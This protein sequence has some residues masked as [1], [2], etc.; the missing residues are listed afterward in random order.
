[1]KKAKRVA[2]VKI[3]ESCASPS[4]AS[5]GD[6]SKKRKGGSTSSTAGVDA[7]K[8]K[9]DGEAS[10]AEIAKIGEEASTQA[11]KDKAADDAKANAA[12]AKE[13]VAQATKRKAGATSSSVMQS[14]QVPEVCDAEVVV[15][16][17]D[18]GVPL[19]PLPTHNAIFLH[20]ELGKAMKVIIPLL[21]PMIWISSIPRG[22]SWHVVATRGSF[23]EC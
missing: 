13:L 10:G 4:K 20:E 7:K 17:S 23:A 6:P 3:P 16:T 1:M 11:E 15:G 8:Q 22:S 9:G 21:L 12:Q 19:Y 2:T 5:E 14:P 18:P